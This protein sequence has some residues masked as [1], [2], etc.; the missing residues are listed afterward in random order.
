MCS[1]SRAA[2]YDCAWSRWH[3]SG[4]GQSQT[5]RWQRRRGRGGKRQQRP[6]VEDGD[7]RRA[8]ASHRHAGHQ[9]V[10]AGHHTRRWV[11]GQRPSENHQRLWKMLPVMYWTLV[12]SSLKCTSCSHDSVSDVLLSDPHI[13]VRNT[14]AVWAVV[15]SY[16]WDFLSPGYYGEGLN[17]I[18]VFSAC[19]LPDSSCPDYHYIMENLFLWVH[20][21]YSDAEHRHNENQTSALKLQLIHIAWCWIN[22]D[23]HFI[24]PQR[25]NILSSSQSLKKNHL[26]HYI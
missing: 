20:T 13:T 2:E 6:P 24:Q 9:A 19:Y 14:V 11:E 3:T 1:Q 25:E 22:Q 5:R 15:R 23:K 10:P 16:Q 21:F 8:G 12:V 7:H 4:L 18:I 17:A 26:I